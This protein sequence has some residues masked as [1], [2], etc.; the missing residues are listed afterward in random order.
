LDATT[1]RCSPQHEMNGW[2]LRWKAL[3]LHFDFEIP[4]RQS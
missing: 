3:I 2:L 1:M 4:D